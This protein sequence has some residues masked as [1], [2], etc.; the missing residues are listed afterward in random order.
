MISEIFGLKCRLGFCLLLD[1]VSYSPP[2]ARQTVELD[3][4]VKRNEAN[5]REL[6]LPTKSPGSLPLARRLA[7]A[8]QLPAQVQLGGCDSRHAGP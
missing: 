7:I 3:V 6:N 8:K 2:L 5:E 4:I 1:R